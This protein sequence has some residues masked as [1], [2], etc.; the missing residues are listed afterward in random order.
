[1]SSKIGSVLG[2]L[3]AVAGLV[4]LILN[5]D[6]IS[7]N[8]VII[9]IQVLAFCLMV[10]ARFTFKARSFHLAANPTEGGLVTKGPYK[11]L[12]HPIY[13]AVIYFG[14]AC[15]IAFPKI[16]VLVAVIFVTGGLFIRM[17]LEE[18]ELKKAYPE[19][20]EY[21]KRAKRLIPFIF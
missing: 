2:Y 8:P 3:I 9:G 14:W 11:L 5:H 21:S 19:Y 20:T 6:I 4:Y 10:W 13:A 12:R 7:K 18:K 17:I 1:M 15:L 16:D